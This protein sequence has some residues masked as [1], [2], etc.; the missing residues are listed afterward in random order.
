MSEVFGINSNR[1]FLT[2]L[3]IILDSSCHWVYIKDAKCMEVRF[4]NI[5]RFHQLVKH[6]EH[7]KD[8]VGLSTSNFFL[9]MDYGFK[10][11]PVTN[12]FLGKC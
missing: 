7:L 11:N 5:Q 6:R 8:F 2:Y 10:L 12:W 1:F 3:I 4:Q 9:L